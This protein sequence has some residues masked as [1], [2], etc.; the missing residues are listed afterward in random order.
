[1]NSPS[2]RQRGRA[3]RIRSIT[4][5]WT[6]ADPERNVGGVW[7][8]DEQDLH[9]RRALLAAIA[10]GALLA[11]AAACDGNTGSDGST[12]AAPAAP[13][14]TASPTPDYTEDTRLVCAEFQSIYDKDVKSLGDAVGKMITYKEAKQASDVKKAEDTAAGDLKTIATK[15][16]TATATAQNP[17]LQ[18][19]GESSADKLEASAKDRKYFAKIKTLKEFNS[20]IESQL[21]TWLSPV[22]GFCGPP[23]SSSPST[24]GPSSGVVPSPSASS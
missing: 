16:R 1:M 17:E 14:P 3:V 21:N 11:G 6:T 7:T 13:A 23:P 8:P 5:G 22:S 24:D 15:I 4:D 18:A 12:A 19:A 10:G 20:T 2:T 9:M